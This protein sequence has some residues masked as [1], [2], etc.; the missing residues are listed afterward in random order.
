MNR[1]R[2]IQT[3]IFCIAFIPCMLVHDGRYVR[4]AGAVVQ[5]AHQMLSPGLTVDLDS[6]QAT[7]RYAANVRP[8]GS[9]C[10]VGEMKDDCLSKLLKL[11]GYVA[12]T[13]TYD[14]SKIKTGNNQYACAVIV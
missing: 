6:L 9:Q 5:Y 13:Y 8:A 10:V 7:V 2:K 1:K 4:T 12:V 14:H 11:A 3:G